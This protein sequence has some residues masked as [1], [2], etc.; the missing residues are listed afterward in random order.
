MRGGMEVTH[1]QLAQQTDPDH[2]NSGEDEDAGNDEYGTVKLH[3]V[4]ASDDLQDQQPHREEETRNNAKRTDGAEE[5]QGPRH[6]LQQEANGEEVEEDPK[7]AGDT[8]VAL[9]GVPRRVR[10]G[11]LADAGAVPGGK[12]RDEAVH[13]AVQG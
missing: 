10:D 8:V 4:L 13:L 12:S 11:N 5:V 6:V 1:L 3:D 2:L 7:G 9:T